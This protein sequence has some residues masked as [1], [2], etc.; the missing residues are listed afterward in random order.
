MPDL[1]SVRPLDAAIAVVAVLVLGLGVFLGY[2]VW[3]SNRTVEASTPAARAIGGL[4]AQVRANPND[5]DTRMRLAQTYSVAGRDRE[6]A[7]Q[8]EQILKVRKDYAPA[9]S[10]LGFIALK[11]KQYKVGENYFQ[12]VVDLLQG[13]DMTRQNAELETAYFYL[14][15]ALME[16]KEYEEAARNFKEAIRIRRDASDSHYALAVCFRELGSEDEYREELEATL[17]FDPKMPEANYDYGNV[18][19]ADGDVAGAAEH[20][21]TSA[22]SAPK[23]EKPAEALAKLGTVSARLAKA[24]SLKASDPKAALV[25][26]RVAAALDPASAPALLAVGQLYEQSKNLNAAAL[27]YRRAL[28]ADPG[29]KDAEAGLKRVT[30]GS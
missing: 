16:Q 20:F 26:A 4:I 24:Q 10:G 17:L 3:Q 9:L 19:L 5:I 23:A 6:A 15:T 14:G 21:R 27:A 28:A 8:Y 29:N 1:K 13:T 22:D 25:E 18:L 12:K 11:Q 2:S 7:T 30:D